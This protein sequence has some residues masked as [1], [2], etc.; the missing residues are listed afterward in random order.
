MSVATETQRELGK[1]SAMTR[2][3]LT[4]AILGLAALSANAGDAY[5]PYPSNGTG[6]A[7]N[8]GPVY[9][10]LTGWHAGIYRAGPQG[11]CASCGSQPERPMRERLEKFMDFLCY[12]PTIPCD[13]RPNTTPYVPPLTAWWHN[14]DDKNC[15]ACNNAGVH[16]GVLGRRIAPCGTCNTCGASGS[17]VVATPSAQPYAGLAPLMAAP[18]IAAQPATSYG[19]IITMQSYTVTKPAYSNALDS[20]PLPTRPPANL[21]G[22]FVMPR[23]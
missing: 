7:V 15:A 14:R 10:P 5:A 13:Y 2:G 8:P 1:D 21:P 11:S 3:L 6:N 23:N 4:A 22:S 16:A 17:N 12:K 18:K 19:P 20:S 9:T